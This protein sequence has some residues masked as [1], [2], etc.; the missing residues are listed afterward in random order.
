MRY[1]L[2]ILLTLAVLASGNKLLIGAAVVLVLLTSTGSLPLSSALLGLSQVNNTLSTN[3]V[4]SSDRK[5]YVYIVEY[6]RPR[7]FNEFKFV[8][9]PNVV[10]F[11]EFSVQPVYK[12]WTDQS[13]NI[14]KR[15]PSGNTDFV[16][17][18]PGKLA[19]RTVNNYT[20]PSGSKQLQKIILQFYYYVKED[21]VRNKE[22]LAKFRALLQR[23]SFR[24]YSTLTAFTEPRKQG[25]GWSTAPAA[26]M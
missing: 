19:V 1:L 10:Y 14:R 23:G 12:S 2:L 3:Y 5:T 4:V 15:R 17:G 16:N 24:S 25:S 21:P 18:E 8:Y 13:F 11:D 20:D 9:D 26:F 6:Y 7:A 22:E